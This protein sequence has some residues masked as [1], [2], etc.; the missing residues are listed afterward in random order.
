[1]PRDKYVLVI[2]DTLSLFSEVQASLAEENVVIFQAFSGHAGVD[3]ALHQAPDLILLGVWHD[4]VNSS[5]LWGELRS[6]PKIARVQI[7]TLPA[8]DGAC[9]PGK[10][11]ETI[12]QALLA[13]KA[14]LSL[15]WVEALADSL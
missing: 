10:M 4:G 8:H 9:D 5:G 6:A 15:D 14:R 7:L 13:E 1:M 2:D 3:I 12:R 11:A